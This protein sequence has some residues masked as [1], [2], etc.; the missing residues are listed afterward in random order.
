MIGQIGPLQVDW[1]RALGYF[2][3]IW[4]AVAFGVIEPPVGVFIAAVPFYKLLTRPNAS[5]PERITGELLQGAAKPV[6]GDSEAVVKMRPA[7]GP[8]S[9]GS[10][11][12]FAGRVLSEGK[13]IWADAKRVSGAGR[14]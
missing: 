6:G 10:P 5:F 1:P 13:S 3:G 14:V 4:A 2:G 7:S 12:G 8:R 9:G 11:N